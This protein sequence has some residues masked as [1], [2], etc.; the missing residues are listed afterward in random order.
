MKT[1]KT[2]RTGKVLHHYD[3]EGNVTKEKCNSIN[4]A[5]KRSREIQMKENGMLGLGTVRTVQ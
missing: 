5:K 3:E 1:M 2:L 4:A